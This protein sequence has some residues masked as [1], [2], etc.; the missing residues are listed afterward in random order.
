MKY[1]YAAIVVLVVL[2]LPAEAGLLNKFRK[3]L[4]SPV[5]L[6]KSICQHLEEQAW[7]DFLIQRQLEAYSGK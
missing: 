5:S 6:A 4:L 1:L 7:T 3:V 2:A